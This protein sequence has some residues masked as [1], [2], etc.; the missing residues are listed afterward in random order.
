MSGR[1][2]LSQV[3]SVG[4]LLVACKGD[5]V[6]ADVEDLARGCGLAGSAWIESSGKLA[7]GDARALGDK[8]ERELLDGCK[9]GQPVKACCAAHRGVARRLAGLGGQVVA[10]EKLGARLQSLGC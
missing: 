7:L 3:L 4:V 10:C 9:A 2:P 1:R 8:S 5:G 6:G